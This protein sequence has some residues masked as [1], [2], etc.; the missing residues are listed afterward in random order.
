MLWALG[1]YSRFIQPGYQRI[2]VEI[3]NRKEN[4][5]EI[6]V[7]AYQAPDTGEIVLVLVNSEINELTISLSVDDIHKSMKQIYVT[8]EDMNLEIIKSEGAPGNIQLP[9]RSIVT[10]ISCQFSCEARG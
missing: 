8:S 7:S 9:A 2:A 10:I 5:P 6:L 3:T 4:F 1:N